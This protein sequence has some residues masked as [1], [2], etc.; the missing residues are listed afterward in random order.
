MSSVE[1]DRKSFLVLCTEQ[2]AIFLTSKRGELDRIK[3]SFGK[4]PAVFP[5]SGTKAQSHF[6]ASDPEIQELTRIFFLFSPK[7]VSLTVNKIYSQREILK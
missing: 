3:E 1:D 4:F 6:S 5:S 2:A 7:T